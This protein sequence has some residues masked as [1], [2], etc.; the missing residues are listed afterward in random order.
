MSSIADKFKEN[1][2]KI[3]NIN[4]MIADKSLFERSYTYYFNELLSE[5]AKRDVR[6]S[7]LMIDEFDGLYKQIDPRYSADVKHLGFTEQFFHYLR[8]LSKSRNFSLVLTGGEAMPLLFD[9]LGEIFNHDR[10]WRVDYLPS[11]D[12]S[13]EQLIRNVHVRS[14]LTFGEDAVRIIKDASSCNPYFVQKICYEL[15]ESAKRKKS[16][17]ICQ[18]DVEES[19]SY[20]VHRGIEANSVQHLYSEPAVPDA[21]SRA[22]ISLAAELE[23]NSHGYGPHYIPVKVILEKLSPEYEDQALIRI[24]ELVR[25]QILRRNPV[26]TN[27]IALMIPLFREW[28]N[29]TGTTYADRA[30]FCRR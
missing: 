25:R 23:G 10:S 9:R 26:E 2:K 15:V 20:L 13:V 30:D 5:L 7:V 24:F 1:A 14:V 27:E 16:N 18:L 22:I 19:L 4:L 11:T 17:H 8:G 6:R 21:L 29:V 28:L 3:L 12:G